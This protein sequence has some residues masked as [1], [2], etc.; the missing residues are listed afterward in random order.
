MGTRGFLGFVVDG[1]AKITYNHYDSYPSG[2]GINVLAWA[3]QI[4]VSKVREQVRAL[5]LVSES[6]APSAE[7]AIQYALHTDSR[8]SDGDD[9]Y[10]TLRHLQGDPQGY[11]DAGVMPDAS[12]FPTNSLFC[13]W[14]YLVDLDRQTLEVYR[15]L[16]TETPTTGRWAGRPTD[17]ENTRRHGEHVGWCDKNGREP[18]E[19]EVPRYKAVMLVRTW[20]LSAFVPTNME[21]L[22]A[23]GYE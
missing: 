1:D 5:R 2:L 22:R 8:V 10:A 14:G 4:D 18:W 17:E 12:D 9:W 16:Q 7:E 3:R 20:M 21:F 19:P 23:L 6:A 11:L 13:E 15:G